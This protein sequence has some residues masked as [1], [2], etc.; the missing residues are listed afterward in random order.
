MICVGL[1]WKEQPGPPGRQQLLQ[2]GPTLSKNTLVVALLVEGYAS[3]QVVVTGTSSVALAALRPTLLNASPNW[4]RTL[5]WRRRPIPVYWHSSA[6][7]LQVPSPG[8]A[9]HRLIQFNEVGASCKTAKLVGRCTVIG[10]DWAGA[11]D[12]WFTV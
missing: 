4:S 11:L 9:R 12:I 5:Y 1:V 7:V 10:V 8:L 2:S 6:L 3:G